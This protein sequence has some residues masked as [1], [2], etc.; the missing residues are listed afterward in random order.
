MRV[1]RRERGVQYTD[2][3]TDRGGGVED[4]GERGRQEGEKKKRDVKRQNERRRKRR[5]EEKE[6][7]RRTGLQDRNR[8]RNNIY[9]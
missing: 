2:G 7:E 9:N 4:E 5:R 8:E 3:E 1:K 6:D